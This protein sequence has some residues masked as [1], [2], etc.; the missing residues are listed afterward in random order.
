M[1]F[2]KISMMVILSFLILGIVAE[3]QNKEVPTEPASPMVPIKVQVVFKEY[4]GTKELSSLP[5]TIPATASNHPSKSTLRMGLRVPIPY[6]NGQFGYQNVGTD[7]DCMGSI[8]GRGLYKI[9]LTLSRSSLYSPKSATFNTDSYVVQ[10]P[11]TPGRE[12]KSTASAFT[13]QPIFSNF[14]TKL[15]LVMRDGQTLESTMATDPI[16]GR[17]LRVDVTLHVVK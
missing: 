1:Q 9:Q 14:G 4:K 11:E 3:G 5:Y 13:S 2:R 12:N 8:L 16:S 7:I 6:G 17:V 15:D 10:Q